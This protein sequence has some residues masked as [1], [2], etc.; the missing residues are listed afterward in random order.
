MSFAEG[1]Y[2][3]EFSDYKSTVQRNEESSVFQIECLLNFL[4]ESLW[5]LCARCVLD[6]PMTDADTQSSV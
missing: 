3:I 6:L 4:C 1:R 2:N 5:I